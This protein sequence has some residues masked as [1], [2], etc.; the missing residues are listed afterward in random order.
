VKD[1]QQEVNEKAFN[2]TFKGINEK[3][4]VPVPEPLNLTEPI[5]KFPSEVFAE[6][7][8]FDQFG[9]LIIEF[10]EPMKTDMNL[11]LLNST[12]STIGIHNNLTKRSDIDSMFKEVFD[13]YVIPND[14]WNV[15]TEGF[16]MQ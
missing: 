1:D 11:T 16:E 4:T 10:N 7:K 8:S 15:Y 9:E 6:V 3:E 13:I 14:K 12:I 5:E 2:V